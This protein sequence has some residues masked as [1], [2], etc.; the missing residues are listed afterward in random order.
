MG[1]QSLEIMCGGTEKVIDNKILEGC[2]NGLALN[3]DAVL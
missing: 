3:H 1:F 2:R